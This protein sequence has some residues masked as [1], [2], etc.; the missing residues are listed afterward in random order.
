LTCSVEILEE[1]LLVELPAD[2]D[3]L[4]GDGVDPH[5]LPNEDEQLQQFLPPPVTNEQANEAVEDA[6][7]EQNAGNQ[8]WGH[9]A[10]PPDNNNMEAEDVPHNAAVM[11]LTNAAVPDEM[12]IQQDLPPPPMENNTIY[13]L[14]SAAMENDVTSGLAS[15]DLGQ[16]NILGS[17]LQS[18]LEAYVSDGSEMEEGQSSNSSNSGD[19]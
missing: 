8:G 5:P 1:N 19:N 17:G 9:W 2:E 3:P 10:L 11:D 16:S 14:S 15:N 6:V 4:P 18:I 12:E 13:G 7:V